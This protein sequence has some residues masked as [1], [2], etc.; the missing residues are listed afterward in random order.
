[1]RKSPFII[2]LIMVIVLFSACTS[3]N[4][5]NSDTNDDMDLVTGNLKFKKEIG[6]QLTTDNGLRILDYCLILVNEYY[7]YKN[8]DEKFGENLL[9][10]DDDFKT[11][12]PK[13]DTEKAIFTDIK[14]CRQWLL[15]LKLYTLKLEEMGTK[16]KLNLGNVSQ[17]DIENTK[18]TINKLE[19]IIPENLNQLLDKYFER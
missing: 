16:A 5:V 7:L 15:N 4:N 1:M 13:N 18:K 11:F 19:S 8:H 12:T 10:M 17:E 2:L 9:L 3:Q 6:S 14:S